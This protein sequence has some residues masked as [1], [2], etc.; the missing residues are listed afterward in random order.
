MLLLDERAP[1]SLPFQ[2]SGIRITAKWE[3]Q[4]FVIQA[5]FLSMKGSLEDIPGSWRG[6][7]KNMVR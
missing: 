4:N 2:T 5:E 7:L 3:S 1:G 6:A